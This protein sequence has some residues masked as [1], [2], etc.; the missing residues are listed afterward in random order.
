MVMSVANRVTGE[1]GWGLR[2]LAR[3]GQRGP[4]EEETSDLKL[5]CQGETALQ[6][7]GVGGPSTEDSRGKSLM[8]GTSM[9]I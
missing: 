4:S 5:G 6:R 8:E 3:G 1:M 7:Q 9:D 2:G